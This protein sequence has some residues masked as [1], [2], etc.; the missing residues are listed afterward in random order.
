MGTTSP[1]DDL[2]FLLAK[3]S[4]RYNE[5]LIGRLREEGFVDVRGSFGSV[6]VPLFAEGEM[7][8][9][10]LAERSRMSKQAISGLVK[11]CEQRGL[12]TRER[13]PDDGRAYR[14]ALTERGRRLESVVNQVREELG[15]HVVA[16]L[17]DEGRDALV[18]GLKGVMDIEERDRG[19]DASGASERGV[20]VHGRDRESPHLGDRVR[21]RAEEGGG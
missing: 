15:D 1:S 13:D 7:R 21:S 11:L 20:R 10:E 19:D 5:L 9:G 14:V 16:A 18:R 2:G 17:G 12:V 6:L 8:A 3:A 4:Q